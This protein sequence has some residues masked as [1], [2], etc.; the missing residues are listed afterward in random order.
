MDYTLTIYKATIPINIQVSGRNHLYYVWND[1][2]MEKRNWRKRKG[3]KR[4]ISLV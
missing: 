1:R 4:A 3:I 2:K